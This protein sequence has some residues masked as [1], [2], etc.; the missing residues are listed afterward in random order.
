MLIVL[1]LLWKN[2]FVTLKNICCFLFLY[3]LFT[4][5]CTIQLLLHERA[6]IG[7]Q[8]LQGW[9]EVHQVGTYSS[10]EDIGFCLS[11]HDF[12]LYL[13]I[14]VYYAK[15]I[16]FLLRVYILYSKYPL[17]HFLEKLH[18]TSILLYYPLHGRQAEEPSMLLTSLLK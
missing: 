15:N 2:K 9:Q 6:V 4:F 14:I 12:S 5:L 3:F 18:C 10:H 8:D 7:S 17:P 13:C 1:C 11:Q 16:R